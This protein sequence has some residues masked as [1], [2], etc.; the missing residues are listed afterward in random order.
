MTGICGTRG[1][2]MIRMC[3]K[4]LSTEGLWIVEEKQ[5][6]KYTKPRGGLWEI[7]LFIC[8]IAMGRFGVL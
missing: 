6:L 8:H 3:S 7:L 5:D 4:E 1:I 2:T